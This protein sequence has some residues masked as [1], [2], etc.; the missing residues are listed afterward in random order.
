MSVSTHWS[1]RIYALYAVCFGTLF[2]LLGNFGPTGRILDANRRGFVRIL[3]R[4]QQTT[5]ILLHS[6]V[7]LFG[8]S[9]TSV[10]RTEQLEIK[11]RNL[12]S[13][14]SACE[15]R[16]AQSSGSATQAAKITLSNDEQKPSILSFAGGKWIVLSGSHDGIQEGDSVL[17]DGVF[18]GMITSVRST[19][20]TIDT[21]ASNILPVLVQHERSGSAAVIRTDKNGI[22][23][24]F[25]KRVDD[26]QTGD[27]F[28]SVPDGKH[29]HKGYPIATLETVDSKMS[30]SVS[31]VTVQPIA[32]PTI[33]AVVSV[34]I[35]RE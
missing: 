30:D 10:S 32:R 34:I 25:T 8:L 21:L 17:I 28:V 22:S 1:H 7:Q 20:S 3:D 6:V 18:L 19:Y 13:Q 16:I 35:S 15:L 11:N 4:S 33:G 14:L 23:A 2:L 5:T 9:L 29:S 31:T 12:Y 27:V 26:L 24:Q